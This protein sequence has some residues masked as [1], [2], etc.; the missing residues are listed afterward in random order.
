[1]AGAAQRAVP[2]PTT[3]ADREAAKK[4]HLKSRADGSDIPYFIKPDGSV[5]YLDNKGGGKLGFNDLGTKLANEAARQAK[6]RSSMPT[7]EMYIDVFGADTGKELFEQERQKLKNIYKYTDSS[8]FDVDHINSSADGGV[9][10]SRNL[11]MQNAS[12]N[13]SE[14]ARGLSPEVKTGMN[15][16]DDPKTQIAMQGPDLTAKQRQIYIDSDGGSVSRLTSKGG[17]I[18][19]KGNA[20]RNLALLGLVAGVAHA[21]DAFAAGDNQEGVARLAET[22]VGEV[23]VVGDVIQ[24]EPTAGADMSYPA[25]AS[26]MQ[27]EADAAEKRASD[28]VAAGPSRQLCFKGGNVCFKAPELGLSEWLTGRYGRQKERAALNGSESTYKPT[29]IPIR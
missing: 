18:S 7:L 27:A 12:R 10:H 16:V 29:E 11:R 26:Q 5:H 28:A 19:F 8:Q 3:Q 13:R 20:M 24:S 9:H 1:M 4:L 15:L 2:F 14:G 23:P 22:A 17:T 25:R 21:G 6:K